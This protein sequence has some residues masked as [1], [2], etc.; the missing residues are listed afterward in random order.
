[1]LFSH[2]LYISKLTWASNIPDSGG[3]FRVSVYSPYVILNKTGLEM[4][5]KSKSLLQPARA[6]AGQ[7]VG[8]G[9]DNEEGRK[10]LP[11]LFSFGS[12]EGQNRAILKVGDSNWSKPQSFD[13]VGS[14][15]EVIVPSPDKQGE[16]HLGLSVMEGE[17]KVGFPGA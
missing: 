8:T 9:G 4:S 5:I 15:V 11:L 10:A 6:A 7:G 17:G 3:A 16:M 12:D 13:A 1:M 14:S 2:P